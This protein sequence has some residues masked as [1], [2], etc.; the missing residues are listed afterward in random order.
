M[1]NKEIMVLDQT[2]HL[3]K[4]IIFFDGYCQIQEFCCSFPIDRGISQSERLV[5]LN[6]AAI[7]QM[8]VLS[9]ERSCL[10]DSNRD[11]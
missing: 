2:M 4:M 5:E 11:E 7:R 3:N 1:K 8:K 9:D 6:R 10:L